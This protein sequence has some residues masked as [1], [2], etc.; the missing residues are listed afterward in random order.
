[1]VATV[2]TIDQDEPS[3]A[4]VARRLGSDVIGL[5]GRIKI[6]E[7]LTPSVDDQGNIVTIY[8]EN[9]QSIEDGQ[10]SDVELEQSSLLRHYL[11]K[12]AENNQQELSSEE[13][14]A[15]VLNAQLDSIKAAIAQGNDEDAQ[16]IALNILIANLLA[17][18]DID[19]SERGRFFTQR[20]WAIARHGVGK[21][22][23]NA[24]AE[25]VEICINVE[26]N[27]SEEGADAQY[28]SVI[29]QLGSHARL[30]Q[31]TDDSENSIDSHFAPHSLCEGKKEDIKSPLSPWP[32]P[33]G[34]RWRRG[35]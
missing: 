19:E 14:W 32:L 31:V 17:T 27:D 4:E 6:I 5:S 28:I 15:F 2:E 7:S 29:D 11:T 9:P 30:L 24:A 26:P 25:N 18:K 8:G 33:R 34:F 13:V 20:M 35:V 3:L 22:I 16:K 23:Y 1:M 12:T 10:I 21:A